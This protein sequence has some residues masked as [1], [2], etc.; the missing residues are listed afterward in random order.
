[1][2]GRCSQAVMLKPAAGCRLSLF[3]SLTFR[4]SLSLTICTLAVLVTTQPTQIVQSLQ[5]PKLQIV[6]R[7]SMISRCTSP[8]RPFFLR[9]DSRLIVAGAA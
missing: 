6:S 1:M 3:L 4:F 2:I 9:C 7:R 8:F 5:I